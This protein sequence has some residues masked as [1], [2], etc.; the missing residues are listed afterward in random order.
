MPHLG[1]PS[2]GHGTTPPPSGPVEGGDALPAPATEIPG[3]TGPPPSGG[4][5]GGIGGVSRPAADD[6][7]ERSGFA[8]ILELHW[9]SEI[10]ELQ[11]FIQS[12]INRINGEFP[13]DPYTVEELFQA[14]LEA[15]PW[16]Q[17]HHQA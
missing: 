12:W 14:E 15:Q 13:P 7:Y 2:A 10:P 6:P 8:N 4:L 16:W 5:E 11:A 1:P 9:A 3:D 17:D